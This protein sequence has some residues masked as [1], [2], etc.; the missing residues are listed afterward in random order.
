MHPS[1]AAGVCI[2]IPPWCYV[3]D[4][5]VPA[6]LLRLF[7]LGTDGNVYPWIVP[8]GSAAGAWGAAIPAPPGRMLTGGPGALTFLSAGSAG[9]GDL[10]GRDSPVHPEFA[11]AAGAAVAY[12]PRDLDMFAG[13]DDGSLWELL[14]DEAG[15][16]TWI[17]HGLPRAGSGGAF[18]HMV[19]APSSMVVN[20]ASPTQVMRL[21]VRSDSGKFFE[22]A[23]SRASGWS[24]IDRGTPGTPLI[25]SPG[26]VVLDT[27][28]PSKPLRLFARGRDLGFYELVVVPSR[29]VWSWGVHALTGMPGGMRWNIN[30]GYSGLAVVPYSPTD[31]YV[32]FFAVAESDPGTRSVVSIP[33]DRLFERFGDLATDRWGWTDHGSP[34]PGPDVTIDADSFTTPSTIVGPTSRSVF[35]GAQSNSLF[36]RRLTAASV[37]WIAHG[38]PGKLNACGPSTPT[39]PGG[40]KHFEVGWK[41]LESVEALR[42]AL[43]LG[44]SREAR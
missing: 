43:D 35:M 10:I 19:G 3:I 22:R 20:F 1:P 21:F 13:A 12:L 15:A 16:F 44:E 41:C 30:T 9:R 39:T 37:D 26:E 27:T 18:E 7:V 5:I 2:Q 40:P 6:Q 11:L 4:P 8:D 31:T 32:S 36:E 38:M 23:F 24:W 28:N 42:A 17:P 34:L 33:E 14:I 29:G 25:D